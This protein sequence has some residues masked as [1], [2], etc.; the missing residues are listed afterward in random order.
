MILL[1]PGPCMTSETV[2]QAA[3]LPDLNHRDPQYMEIAHDI[4]QKLTNVAPGFMPYVFG[5]SGSTAMEAMVTSCIADGPCLILANGFYSERLFEI[6][7]VYGIPHKTLRWEWDEPWDMDMVAEELKSTSYESV[8]AVHHETSTGRLNPI[9]ALAETCDEHHSDLLLDVVS[10]LG[11]EKIDFDKISALCATANK[12]LHGL[13]GVAFVMTN[14]QFKKIGTVS[15]RTYTLGLAQYGVDRPPHTPPTS[16]MRAFRQ[17]LIEFEEQGGQEARRMRYVKQ[18]QYVRSSL[19]EKGFEFYT[20]HDQASCTTT[21]ATIPDG[22]TSEQWLKANYDAGYTLFEC[23]EA[24]REKY[25]QVST[26]G[27]VTD[28][29]VEGWL[30]ATS[31]RLS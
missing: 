25:F 28:E 16:A 4:R 8:L 30:D 26:M 22:F 2:R 19:A 5:G 17:A 24:M 3:A 9:E 21:V 10:S 11:A 14:P 29:M 23:K 12:C 7:S 31:D 18:A 1:T 6:F 13:P 27:E 20:P 15:R